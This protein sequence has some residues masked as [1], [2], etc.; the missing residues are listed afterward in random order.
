MVPICCF[1]FSAIETPSKILSLMMLVSYAL[2]IIRA[3]GTRSH[4][5]AALVAIVLRTILAGQ[6]SGKS[7]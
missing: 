5:A 7:S 3:D 1:T 6:C 4:F 2:I